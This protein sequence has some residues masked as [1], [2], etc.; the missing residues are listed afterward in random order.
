MLDHRAEV[1]IPELGQTC[2]CHPSFRL[3]GA[4]NPLEEG[5]GRR[6]LPR[7]FLNRFTRVGISLLTPQDLTL[8]AG[9]GRRAC[10]RMH[11]RPRLHS[12]RGVV[13]L[14]GGCGPEQAPH[15]LTL[16]NPALL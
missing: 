11:I 13:G 4:Q 12:H 7:S 5:G 2:A 3:F 14:C 16:A 1:V 10:P 6:G 8:I 15:E 9:V